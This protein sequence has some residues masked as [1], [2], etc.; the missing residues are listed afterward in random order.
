MSDLISRSSIYNYIK[1]QINPYGKPFK[2]TAYE[3]GLK[4]MDYI[5]NATT[6]EAVPVVR[7]KWIRVPSSDMMTGAAYKCSECGKM[8]Y[9]SF[10]P[11]FC[12]HCGADM[13]KEV[14][15]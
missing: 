12:Q 7:G 9:G 4:V 15:E 10:L 14:A 6:V 5:E 13:R 8:R 1:A 11:N 3:F 2:G